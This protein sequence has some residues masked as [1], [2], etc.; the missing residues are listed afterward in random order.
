M[1]TTTPRTAVT[2]RIGPQNVEQ[3]RQLAIEHDSTVSRLINRAVADKL[4]ATR[5]QPPNTDAR[6]R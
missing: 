4:A 3:L 1:S 6:D 2:A 5:A